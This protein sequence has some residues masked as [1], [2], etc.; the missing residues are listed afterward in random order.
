MLASIAALMLRAAVP[1]FPPPTALPP[2]ENLKYATGIVQSVAAD[3]RSMVL[4]TQAGALNVNIEQVLAYGP[5]GASAPMKTELIR[6]GE[7]VRV[8]Y[9]VDDGAKAR[10]VDL[11]APLP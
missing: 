5:A 11:A 2:D 7:Q 9:Y 1:A 6:Q 8:Y 3:G 10:E 4:A